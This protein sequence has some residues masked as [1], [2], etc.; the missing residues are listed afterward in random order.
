[1]PASAAVGG[2]IATIEGLASHPIVAALIQGR[3]AQCG[4]C[5]PGIVMAA[6][7]LLDAAPT[8]TRGQ[9]AAV[10]DGDMCRRGARPRILRAIEIAA[11]RMTEGGA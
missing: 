4:Y 10:L 2:D 8:P 9:I 6:K 5:T 1:M 3:A 7:A 11:A